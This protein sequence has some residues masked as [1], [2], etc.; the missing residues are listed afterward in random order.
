MFWNSYLPILQTDYTASLKSW[1]TRAVFI[2]RRISP[3]YVR[4]RTWFHSWPSVCLGIMTTTVN[5]IWFW[6]NM[7]ICWILPRGVRSLKGILTTSERE[8]SRQ[9]AV[10]IVISSAIWKPYG[11]RAVKGKLLWINYLKNSGHN[12]VEDHQWWEN[13]I[14]FVEGIFYLPAFMFIRFISS[15]LSA[16]MKSLPTASSNA[17]NPVSKIRAWNLWWYTARRRCFARG[18]IR[19]QVENPVEE[20]ARGEAQLSA[21]LSYCN[22]DL[23]PPKTFSWN[24]VP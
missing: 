11:I 14:N 9:I 3:E 12:I 24:Q 7:A 20:E 4:K 5:A 2:V 18:Y 23:V 22:Q 6:L 21:C 1:S 15:P 8:P 16:N 19:C 17:S 13:W 10:N